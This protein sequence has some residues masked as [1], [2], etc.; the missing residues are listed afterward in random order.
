MA[1]FA[2]D[3]ECIAFD[4]DK[5][6]FV[7]GP[8]W[9]PSVVLFRKSHEPAKKGEIFEVLAPSLVNDED[10]GHEMSLETIIRV[11]GIGNYSVVMGH[12]PIATGSPL[13]AAVLQ[14]TRAFVLVNSNVAIIRGFNG[15]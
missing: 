10:G 8:R 6:T 1:K 15:D 11:H 3:V 9:S 7:V 2:F 13:H 4:N 14:F 5:K 12:P